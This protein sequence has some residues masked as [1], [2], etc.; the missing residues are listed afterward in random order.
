M[1]RGEIAEMNY[2]DDMKK[3]KNQEKRVTFGRGQHILQN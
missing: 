2:I 1:H 3:Q